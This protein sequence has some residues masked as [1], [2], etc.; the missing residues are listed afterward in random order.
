MDIVTTVALVA[1]IALQL[2]TQVEL[3]LLR[4]RQTI[5]RAAADVSLSMGRVNSMVLVKAGAIN[6]DDM[7][8]LL[9]KSVKETDVIKEKE[10]SDE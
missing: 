2:I 1:M 4:K 10:S 8:K 3:K 7:L 5:V 9:S 6:E